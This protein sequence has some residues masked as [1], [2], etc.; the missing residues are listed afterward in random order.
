MPRQFNIVQTINQIGEEVDSVLESRNKEKYFEA[1][2]LLYSL[3]EN[4]LKWLLFIKI[5]WRKSDRLLHEEEVEKLRSFCR[6]SDFYTA[7]NTSLSLDLINVNLYKK[8]DKVRRERNDVIHQLWIYKNRRN[9]LVL[10]KTLER[11]TR[12]ARQLAKTTSELTD[13]IGLEQI[14]EIAL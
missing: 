8:I 14:Y 7:L 12:V 9:S 3:I 1:I 13:E 10:R 4:L 6:T 5:I 2:I 11:L